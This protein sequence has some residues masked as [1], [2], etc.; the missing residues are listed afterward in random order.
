M[1]KFQAPLLRKI[2]LTQDVVQFDFSLEG[3]TVDFK[4]GQFF[5]IELNDAEGRAS[6]AY[7]VASTPS[8]KAY[9]SLCVK[10]LPD[11]RGSALLS[12]LA[13]GDLASFMAPFG[14]FLIEE[15][16]LQS[17]KDMV[18]VAT[19][20]GLA[21]F[22]SMIPTLFEQRFKGNIDLYFGVRHEED[23]FYVEELRAFE[24]EHP[25][26]KAHIMLSQ[27]GETWTGLSGRVTDFL[28]ELMVENRQIYICG[29][30][31]MVKTVKTLMQEKGVAK[32][33]LHWEQFTAL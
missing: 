27:P 13:V 4:A 20:T 9:F 1:Q 18:M 22:M 26:F 31:D 29:N 23:L 6:R 32:E 8:N 5:M 17:Q 11:G 19:G 14:H 24:A 3:L 12:D 30:G 7:S 10:L 16:G 28:K 2:P 25:T 33:D 21:P 15:N